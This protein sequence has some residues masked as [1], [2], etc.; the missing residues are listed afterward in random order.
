VY[1]ALSG[2]KRQAANRTQGLADAL[3]VVVAILVLFLARIA[4]IISFIVVMPLV[5]GV[6][7]PLACAAGRRGGPACTR[8]VGSGKE[9]VGG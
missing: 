7:L 3:L 8:P 9:S 5:V 4:L 2:W 6:G 1:C